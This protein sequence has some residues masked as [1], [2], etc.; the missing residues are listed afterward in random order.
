MD[1]ELQKSISYAVI[2]VALSI[3]FYL[4]W[5]I[6]KQNKIEYTEKIQKELLANQ[7]KCQQVASDRYEKD[8][9]D[10]DFPTLN[11]EYKYDSETGSCFYLGGFILSAGIQKFIID[12]YTNKTIAEFTVNRENEVI[13]GNK[14][15]FEFIRSKYFPE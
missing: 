8:A 6:P 10:V 7:Q 3:A 4:L 15:T 9:K 11:P 5:Y 1:R 13:Y 2:I 12:V 14:N